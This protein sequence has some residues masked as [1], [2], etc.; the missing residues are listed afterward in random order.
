MMDYFN[1]NHH[2][3]NTF[4]FLF[5]AFQKLTNL[6]S[7]KPKPETTAAPTMGVPQQQPGV[8]Q[9]APAAPAAA[10]PAGVGD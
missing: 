1:D 6:F 7:S 10:A 9:P 5:C 2:L 8:A 4:E 3:S